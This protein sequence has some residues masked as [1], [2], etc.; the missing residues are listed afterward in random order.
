MAIAT[1][2]NFG[3]PKPTYLYGSAN[4]SAAA[5]EY[6][7][8]IDTADSAIKSALDLKSPV[9]SPT[10]TTLVNVGSNAV[11]ITPAGLIKW[12]G[13][14]KIDLTTAP[15]NLSV[16]G[17][18][19]IASGSGTGALS[20]AGAGLAVLYA[21]YAKGVTPT[22]GTIASSA[23]PYPSSDGT[24][25]GTKVYHFTVTALAA[26]AELQ[27]PR[28]TWYDGE[29]LIV[30]VKGDA[31]PRALTYVTSAGGYRVC[32][33]T[34]G[35]LPT[36]TVASKTL[37]LKFVYNSADSFFDYIGFAGSDF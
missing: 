21:P 12:Q 20:N 11:Q 32:T 18:L 26:A 37:Y 16:D 17:T 29:Q 13:S 30:R 19:S 10:F 1:S 2:T 22:I 23:T 4:P 24:V 35:A 15:G 27:I 34:P 28:G 36:T 3:L 7:S 33:T 31:T 8:A 5:T 9:D 25:N 14:T 6:S